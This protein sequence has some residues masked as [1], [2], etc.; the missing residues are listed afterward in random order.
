MALYSHL[1]PK[2]LDNGPT[3]IK[4]DSQSD[5]TRAALH[6]NI[7]CTIEAF[8][9]VLLLFQREPW[10]LISPRNRCHLSFHR[11]TDLDRSIRWRV[12]ECVGQIVC[13]HLYQTI[14]I[15]INR[16][17]FLYRHLQMDASCKRRLLLVL[18]C[19]LDNAR[20][21]A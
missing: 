10:P 7:R 4:A 20:K 12:F 16:H 5:F 2:L 6:F 9:D 11:E 14:S 18:N 13:D 19:L 3:E 21:I 15:T 17:L 8:P 1:P